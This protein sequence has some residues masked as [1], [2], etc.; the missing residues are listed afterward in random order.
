MKHL[1]TSLLI[2]AFACYS[3][4]CAQNTIK[5]KVVDE[6]SI[7]IELANVAL[8]TLPD[9]SL[10]TGSV[11]D[12]LGCFLIFSDRIDDTFLRVSMIGYEPQSMKTKQMQTVILQP[13]ATWL[14]EVTVSGRR[15]ILKMEN[16]AIRVDVKN[17]VLEALTTSK[18]VIAQLPF[19]AVKDENFTIL[20][21]GKPLIYINNRLIRDENELNQL[22]PKDIK[23]IQIITTPGA[24]YDA[25]VKSVI[26][27]TLEK[28]AG[29]GISGMI[30]TKE[31]YSNVFF[32]NEYL[33][34]NYRKGSFDI[35]GSLDYVHDKYSS[36]FLSDQFIS[37]TK[38]RS[39]QITKEN[40]DGKTIITN[41]T[42]GITFNPNKN[43][44]TGLRYTYNNN[45]YNGNAYNKIEN[46]QSSGTEQI[47]QNSH[48]KRHPY[49]HQVNGYFDG[50]L[51][52]KLSLNINT[53][54]L[55]GD[56]KNIQ[57]SYSVENPEDIIHNENL[58]NYSLFAVKGILSY[59]FPAGI[60]FMGSEYSHT[61][62]IQKYFINKSELGI[63]NTNDE[64][65]QNRSAIF[66]TYQI[67]KGKYEMNVGV[68]GENICFNYFENEVL[69]KEQSKSYSKFFP[70]LS[71]SY[72]E[73]NLQCMLGY[74]RKIK[75]PTY[76]QLRSNVQYS[77]PFI[78]EAG[79]PY[80]LPEISS[81]ITAM[82]SWKDLQ[83]MAS[84]SFNR[85]DIQLV[86]SQ[87]Q[88]K[89]IILL[90]NENV[91]TSKEA[92]IGISFAPTLGLWKP[93]FEV[94]GT[95][96]WLHFENIPQN[97]SSPIFMAKWNNTFLFPADWTFRL[98]A[99]YQSSGHSGV[100][101]LEPSW[102]VNLKLSKQFFNKKMNIMLAANDIFRT[103]RDKWN[104]NYDNIGMKYDRTIH[105]RLAYITITYN[106]NSTKNRYKGQQ[107]SDE[108]NRLK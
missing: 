22:S 85:N 94:T 73:D 27:I 39:E 81:N 45:N 36:N 12:S 78:Y 93:R 70:N 15:K 61:R 9:S 23:F 63:T 103:N 106:F 105:S 17:T 16:G 34:L 48:I 91:P 50:S 74:E 53:D 14:D 1:Y 6:N 41:P 99:N 82:F 28:T 42:V 4:L 59:S 44:S 90:K 65:K 37:E 11:T 75:Y 95:K 31:G 52:D 7:P 30:Y 68:R 77:S 8:Y 88:D 26:K 57:D 62:I 104:V 38:G 101:Y 79:N 24:Q 3:D 92:N 97:Y 46:I 87:F 18:E 71:F 19:V 20:G 58:R 13:S 86:F 54:Y 83:T 47:A 49:T 21:K 107:A 102:G 56:E 64:L 72:A 66:A 10:I 5:G 51:S 84:Y 29:E 96:Q 55:K 32:G 25:T 89:S 80:L 98:D 69:N 33:S 100:I 2:L 35:F 76:S 67:Q 60:L 40:E 43:I 108:I